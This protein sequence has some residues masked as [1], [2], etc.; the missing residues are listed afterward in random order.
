MKC[1]I[2]AGEIDDDLGCVCGPPGFITMVAEPGSLGESIGKMFD[3]QAEAQAKIASGLGISADL[4]RGDSTYATSEAALTRLKEAPVGKI[5]FIAFNL[6][7][8]N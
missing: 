5:Q 6:P 2:C 3:I 1:L 7:D 8:D 4:L